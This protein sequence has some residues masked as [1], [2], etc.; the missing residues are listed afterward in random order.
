MDTLQYVQHIPVIKSVSNAR[1][2][3]KIKATTTQLQAAKREKERMKA[4]GIQRGKET[5][6]CAPVDSFCHISS[7][8]TTLSHLDSKMEGELV[9][10]E[11]QVKVRCEPVGSVTHNLH[12]MHTRE[13]Q[14]ICASQLIWRRL[15]LPFNQSSNTPAPLRSRTCTDPADP[16]CWACCSSA[17]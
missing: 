16:P 11:P 9:N 13:L 10:G 2:P 1:R 5:A 4:R 6:H 17:F 15:K 7:L 14:F 12:I 8:C 3:M